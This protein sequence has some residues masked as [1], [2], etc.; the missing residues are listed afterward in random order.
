MR[1]LLTISAAAMTIALAS[2]ASAQTPATSPFWSID[3]RL[4]DSDSQVEGQGRHDEHRIRLEAG[5]R[6]RISA[7]SDAFDTV[8]RLFRAGQDAP[9]AENDDFGGT[10]NS[11]LSYTPAESGDYVL[12][13]VSF[14]PEGRG[15]YRAQA[16]QLPPLPPPT[17]A[18]PGGRARTGWRLWNGELSAADADRDGRHFD[19]YP[20][21]MAAGETRLIFA[22]SSAFDIMVEVLRASDREGE[23]IEMDDDSGNGFNAMLG[24]QAERAGDYVVRVTSYVPDATGGYRLRISDPLTPPPLPPFAPPAGEGD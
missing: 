22:E 9:V 21:R 15:A 16:E 2:P 14:S 23:A 5:R 4:E 19:D 17:L 3:G 20:V 13:V 18:R 10:L 8:I 6:Y 11:R 12:R 1:A 7:S 24:F